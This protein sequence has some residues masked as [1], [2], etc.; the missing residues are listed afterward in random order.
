MI[1][2]FIGPMSKNIVDSIL[3]FT[4][5]TGNKIGLI[6][7][8]RQVEWD[9]GYVNNWT[10]EQFSKYADKL[11]LKRD[12]GGPGQG[13]KEDDGYESLK[14]DCKYLDLIHIDPWKKYPVYKEGME[15]TINMIKFC[16]ALNSSME[17]EVGTE[18][19]IRRFEPQE[20]QTFLKDLSNRLPPEVFNKIKYLVIQTGTSLKGNNNTGEYDKDRLLRMV[21]VAKEY[22]LLSKEHNGDYISPSLIKEKMSLG[23]DSINIAPEFGL[24]ETQTYLDHID[25]EKTLDNFWKVCLD[26]GRWKKWV[27]SDFDPHTQ[28]V[29]LIKICGHYVLSH[30]EFLDGVRNSLPNID[31]IIKDRVKE[32]L[33]ELYRNG[34]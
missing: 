5:E 33:Q 20:L 10:T 24:I 7:S 30:Q 23:L 11:T 9:G 28:K 3:E 17:Y 6:P 14:E 2:Y 31:S 1:K 18:E 22:G 16:Y 8:R 15:W 19:A 27:D 34:Y 4:Q 21:S 12:H 25:D 32:K 29:D 26:S 13:Y